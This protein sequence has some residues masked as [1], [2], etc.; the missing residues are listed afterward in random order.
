LD[1]ESDTEPETEPQPEPAE[2]QKPERR[3][4]EKPTPEPSGPY[5]SGCGR[6][7][8][9]CPLR[10]ELGGLEGGFG[11]SAG[12]LGQERVGQRAPDED[13]REGFDWLKEGA[14]WVD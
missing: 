14:T 2:K 8:I 3:G 1:D 6:A 9:L 4:K 5:C 11:G 10:K 13:Q 12:P 7:G